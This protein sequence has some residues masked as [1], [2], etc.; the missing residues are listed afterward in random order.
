[1]LHRKGPMPDPAPPPK[2]WR[3]PKCGTKWL[4]TRECPRCASEVIMHDLSNAPVPYMS[5]ARLR[6]T[7]AALAKEIASQGGITIPQM[8]MRDLIQKLLD[9]A[10]HPFC[11]APMKCARKGYCTN[12]PACN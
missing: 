7:Q 6:F 9:S 4:D 1:M 2:V 12:D 10:P 11:R 3:C 8:E 5:C